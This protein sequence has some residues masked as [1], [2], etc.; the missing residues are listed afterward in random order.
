M[1]MIEVIPFGQ[2]TEITGDKS[3]NLEAVDTDDIQRILVERYPAMAGLRYAI[4]V[5]R[6][7]VK[8]NVP[9]VDGA[10]VALLPPFSGG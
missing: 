8:S 5:D 6:V 3:F 9:L 1:N 2:I 7:V 4:A 10:V